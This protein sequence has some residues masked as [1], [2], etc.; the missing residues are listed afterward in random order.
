MRTVTLF[1]PLLWMLN[2]ALAL[3]TVAACASPNALQIKGGAPASAAPV[4]FTLATAQGDKEAD[5]LGALQRRAPGQFPVTVAPWRMGDPQFEI[6]TIK[7][8][9]S[10]KV[11][12]AYVPV[13][14][15]HD[16]GITAFDGLVA[17]LALGNYKA[18]LEVLRSPEAVKALDV[19]SRAGVIAFGYIPGDFRKPLSIDTILSGPDDLKGLSM[20][21]R[22]LELVEKTFTELGARVVVK[23]PCSLEGTNGGEL[24][25]VSAQGCARFA[26]GGGVTA[27]VNFWPG[28]QVLIMNRKVWESLTDAQ[29]TTLQSA[30]SDALVSHTETVKKSEA[31]AAKQ[32]CAS[33]IPVVDAT[34]EQLSAWRTATASLRARIAAEPNTA[35]LLAAIARIAGP[36]PSSDPIQVCPDA[37]PVGANGL[38][39]AP[40]TL[41]GRYSATLVESELAHHMSRSDAHANAGR[42][43]MTLQG[44][45]LQMHQDAVDPAAA[46]GCGL[47]N[48]NMSGTYGLDPSGCLQLTIT[49]PFEAN[50][51]CWAYQEFRDRLVLTELK[52]GTG[53]DYDDSAVSALVADQPWV[54]IPS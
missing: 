18:Q 46:N 15:L 50:Y 16:V 33:G 32:L 6:N 39:L 52:I 48:V 44:G 43:T 11:D 19:A 51:G 1:R 22:P 29:R 27:N 21:T 28:V 35:P 54:R 17:P 9:A 42:Y 10:G 3:I 14:G 53:S 37:R 47:C 7:D 36:S 40:S 24:G 4:P 5:F 49:A 23:K 13:P 38:A 31:A 2:A 41:N 34:E 12:A 8:V 26:P 45:V 30:A 25:L 20:S